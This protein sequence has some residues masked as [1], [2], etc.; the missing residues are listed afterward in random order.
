[1]Y[2]KTLEAPAGPAQIRALFVFQ[3]LKPDG[4]SAHLLLRRAAQFLLCTKKITPAHTLQNTMNELT[5]KGLKRETS[6]HHTQPC[7]PPTLHFK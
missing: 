7:P 3:L 2:T 1:M 6:I 4:A 5:R